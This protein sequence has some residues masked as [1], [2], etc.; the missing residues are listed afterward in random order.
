MDEDPDSSLGHVLRGLSVGGVRP[1]LQVRLPNGA[2]A[3]IGPQQ[4]EALQAHSRL[5]D[6]AQAI[7]GMDRD[8]RWSWSQQHRAQANELY[9]RGNV[10]QAMAKYLE[11]GMLL[12]RAVPQ[13]LFFLLLSLFAYLLADIFKIIYTIVFNSF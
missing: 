6:T 5:A 3:P 7:A 8:E 2:L 11:V 13:P 9:R 10:R 1:S 4:A 12:Y